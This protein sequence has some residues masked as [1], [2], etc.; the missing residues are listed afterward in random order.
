MTT[1]TTTR[2]V[3]TTD[4]LELAVTE[5]AG[6]QD[7]PMIVCVH[8]YPDNQ[9][10][11]APVATR[12]S[13]RFRV[14][15]YDVRG[16]GDS[17]APADRRGYRI[18]QLNADLAA[19]MDA[20]SPDRSVHLL[21]HDWGSIQTW[22][23]VSGNIPAARIASYTSISGPDLDQA[24]V[25]LRGLATH[26]LAGA[27]KRLKQLAESYYVFLFQAPGLPE[28]AWRSGLLEKLLAREVRGVESVPERRE[29]DTINGIELYRANILGRL[30]RPTPRRVTVPVQV[31]APTRDV[32]VSPAMATEAPVPYVDDLTVV[33]VDARHWVVLRQPDRIAELV[34]G[35]VTAHGG[36][37]GGV[38]GA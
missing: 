31:I 8:G 12:L 20:V 5:Y 29:R 1:S 19:V 28:A 9:S 33:E 22:A 16:C 4:G 30:G 37:R 15:T 25:W 27:R 3:A 17:D 26:G 38:T 13:R 7:A 23:A 18:P 36:E 32:Y 10:V 14:V 2:R 35:F 6:P 24:G 34:A 21:A 11:W